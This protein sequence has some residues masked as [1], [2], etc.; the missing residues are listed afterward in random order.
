MGLN[1]SLNDV[2]SRVLSTKPVPTFSVVFSEVRQEESRRRVMMGSIQNISAASDA[3]AVTLHCKIHTLTDDSSE[4]AGQNSNNIKGKPIPGRPWCTKCKKPNQ[5]METCWHIHGK[6]ADL[7]PAR[8][9]RANTALSESTST[10]LLPFT[11][12]QMEVF[13]R[14]FGQKTQPQS[15]L[16]IELG[17]ATVRGDNPLAFLS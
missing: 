16:A 3:S 10:T 17:N 12:E 7:K 15:S 11:R 14:Y 5:T 4:L 13:H 6:P 8:E 1:N 2:R 9:R